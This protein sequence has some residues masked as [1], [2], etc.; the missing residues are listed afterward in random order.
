MGVSRI[1]NLATGEDVRSTRRVLQQLGTEISDRG[2]GEVEVNSAGLGGYT[3]PETSL[4]AGNSG[5]T[6]RLMAGVLSGRSFQSTLTGDKS[7]T[8][9]PMKRITEP[10]RLMGADIDADTDGTAPLVIRPS[11]LHGIDYTLPVASAQVK[12]A[13]ILAGLQTEEGTTVV[14]EDRLSRRHTEMM[15]S[16]LGAPV[17]IDGAVV[18]V[19]PMVAP[20][21]PFNLRIPGDPSSAAYWATLAAIQPG[22][23]CRIRD[24]HLSPERTAYF[25][26]LGA[27]GADVELRVQDRRM[28][29]RG[30]LVVRHNTL[31]GITLEKSMVPALIDELPLL[32]VA[33]M[34]AS[35]KTEVTGAGELRYKETDRIRAVVRNGSAMNADIRGTDDGFVIQG[36]SGVE[37]GELDS[38]GD[39]RIALAFG[40]AAVAASGPSVMHGS[41]AA[42]ISYP[43]F[44]ETLASLIQH[45][46]VN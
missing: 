45:P 10:L 7:L 8:N 24:I 17:G 27:M 1:S 33:G 40:I 34:F 46:T 6:I 16:S 30:D 3:Q 43:E 36:G 37:G 39:H 32:A 44:W 26:V 18:T 28:E 29:P 25:D 38:F 4:D 23:V 9:R 42:D 2:K 13:V 12:S 19:N 15:L 41:E 21:N 20:L 11:V 31:R 5:T 35:G 22:S 14:R